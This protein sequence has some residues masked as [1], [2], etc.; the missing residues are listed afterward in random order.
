MYVCICKA[1]TDSDIRTAVN[2]GVRS[3][4]ALSDNCGA[5][6]QCGQCKKMAEELIKDE[7]NKAS[8]CAA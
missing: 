5:A 3:M 2:N 4:A 7:L 1:I 8:S 6:T